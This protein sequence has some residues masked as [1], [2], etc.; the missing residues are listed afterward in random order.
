MRVKLQNSQ[1]HS[2]TFIPTPS[3]GTFE[4]H[5]LQHCHHLVCVC[6]CCQQ[7]LKPENRVPDPPNDF[8]IVSR[9]LRS[10][11]LS[12]GEMVNR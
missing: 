11:R 10:F 3:F 7:A 5:L 6:F 2:I 1:S 4:I 12:N 9:M 8:T